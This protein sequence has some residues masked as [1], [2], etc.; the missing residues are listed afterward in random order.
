MKLLADLV[1]HLNPT[2]K[3]GTLKANCTSFIR[4]NMMSV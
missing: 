3:Q 1:M 2:G 4:P